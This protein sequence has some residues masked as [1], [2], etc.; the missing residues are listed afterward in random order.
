MQNKNDIIT[1]ASAAAE[2]NND[3]LLAQLNSDKLNGIERN[4]QERDL[5]WLIQNQQEDKIGGVSTTV[6]KITELANKLHAQNKLPHTYAVFGGWGSG[7]TH[8][9]TELGKQLREQNQKVVYFNAFKYA[10]YM[11]IV[12]SLIYRILR[13]VT[14]D[15]ATSKL[16]HQ[17]NALAQSHFR[18]VYSGLS[19]PTK[20]FRNSAIFLRN[21]QSD[22]QLKQSAKF[23]G[24][25]DQFHDTLVEALKDEQTPIFILIDELDRC[26]PLEA[27]DVI[28]QLRVL[29]CAV[30]VPL[31]FVLAANP[32]PIGRAIQK[33]FGLD[34]DDGFESINILEKFVDTSSFID[35][36]R[37]L[38]SF[39]DTSWRRLGLNPREHSTVLALSTN[40]S[41]QRLVL[42][43][44]LQQLPPY[45]NLRLLV[46]S[47]TTATMSGTKNNLW[48][49]WYLELLKCSLPRLVSTA[50]IL[51]REL[52]NMTDIAMGKLLSTAYIGRIEDGSFLST[53]A[54]EVNAVQCFIDAFIQEVP[55]Q[56]GSLKDSSR[57]SAVSYLEQLGNSTTDCTMLAHLCFIDAGPLQNL[58]IIPNQA[59]L[60]EIAPSSQASLSA[61]L[62]LL[63]ESGL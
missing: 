27:F 6:E 1:Q 14:P 21:V 10:A 62:Q 49:R 39:I 13:V 50:S 18:K 22:R 56:I 12:P 33:K 17:A 37:S 44:G 29:F 19:I 35:K 41:K 59:K 31:F 51:S 34:N 40:S 36:T 7:K 60:S 43:P 16:L 28:K 52:T 55:R 47:L 38:E 26:D 15:K 57:S 4:H 5:D 53:Y 46:K 20:L 23:Y 3:D 32:Q 8:L 11:E 25:V 54:E 45:S 42:P 9:L 30:N 24:R 2:E 63:N 61:L 58:Q 48:S